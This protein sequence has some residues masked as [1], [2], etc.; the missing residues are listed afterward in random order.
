M[1]KNV[2]ES[3]EAADENIIRHIRIACWI[4][5]ATN[6]RSEYV[7]L[8]AFPLQHCLHERASV[9]RYTYSTLPVFVNF[10]LVSVGQ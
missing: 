1:W 9:L 3:R 10:R 5:K 8:L 7:T 6:T 2:V 4:P